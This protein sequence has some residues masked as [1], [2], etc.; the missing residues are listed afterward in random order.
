MHRAF[1]VS[2]LVASLVGAPGAM[3]VDVSL[4]LAIDQPDTPVAV[5]GQRSDTKRGAFASVTLENV[6]GRAVRSVQPGVLVHTGGGGKAALRSGN[7]TDVELPSGGS[8]VVE[9]SL[10][11]PAVLEEL[12]KKGDVVLEL[13]VLAVRFADGSEWKFD[14]A[15][16][17]RFS[18]LPIAR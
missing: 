18:R 13:G 7:W 2:L 14:V 5:V 6:S 3:G 17:G 16:S 12:S 10:V 11:P 15:K 8:S 9:T 1:L 4:R